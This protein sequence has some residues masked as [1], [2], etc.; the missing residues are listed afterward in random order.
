MEPEEIAATGTMASFEP[1]RTIEPFPNCFSICPSVS[2]RVRAR[3]FSSMR[4]L[5]VTGLN[6]RRVIAFAAAH[7]QVFAALHVDFHGVVETIHFQRLGAIEDVV[8]VTQFV[9]N[10]L[11]RLVQIRCLEREKRLTTS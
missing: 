5:I 10:I 2:P 7:Q 9:R 1:S 8:L 4:I 11:E 6:L 3:S